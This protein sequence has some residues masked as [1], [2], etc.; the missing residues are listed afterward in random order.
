[1]RKRDIIRLWNQVVDQT[2]I[3]KYTDRQW[4]EIYEEFLKSMY[5]NNE[6]YISVQSVEKLVDELE[7]NMEISKSLNTSSDIDDEPLSALQNR[8][9][10][11]IKVEPII[12]LRRST[13]RCVV[14]N[15]NFNQ[16]LADI[17][18]KSKQRQMH[19]QTEM[20]KHKDN[21][22]LL[23]LGTSPKQEKA[24]TKKINKQ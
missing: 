8:L 11:K 12:P 6:P 14:D 20:A 7:E 9:K 18:F 22:D 3:D 15:N 24:Q 17:K 2:G 1:M 5:D 13:P 23:M 21:D 4:Q 10:D 19:F 16:Q